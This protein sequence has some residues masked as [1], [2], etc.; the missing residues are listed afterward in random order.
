M[1]SSPLVSRKGIAVSFSLLS[2][3]SAQSVP[4]ASF[5]F[6]GGAPGAAQYQLVDDYEPS[7]FFDKFNFYSVSA[8]RTDVDHSVDM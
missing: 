8:T 3:V 5:F 4:G 7:T 2:C 6:G 1:L